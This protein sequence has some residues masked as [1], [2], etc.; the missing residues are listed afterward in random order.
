METLRAFIAIEIE[1]EIRARL[2]EFQQKLKQTD[3]DVRWVKPENIH[4][5]LAFLGNIPASILQPL[6]TALREK[7]QSLE[8]FRIDIQGTGVF[9]RRNRPSVVWAGIQETPALMELQ[10]CVVDALGMV[11]V[12]YHDNRFRPHLT[13]GRFK[14]LDQLDELFQTLEK[15]AKAPFGTQE[16]KAVQIIQSELLPDGAKYTVLQ[17]LKL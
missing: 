12:D 13:L 17:R 11:P 10:Q 14:S 5:T 7:F 8:P 6:E 2:S 16:V 9:G 15:E 1:S 4:L 3:A